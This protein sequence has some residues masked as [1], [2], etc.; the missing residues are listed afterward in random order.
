MEALKADELVAMAARASTLG[1]FRVVRS[2]SIRTTTRFGLR[3]MQSL[4]GVQRPR[5]ASFTSQNG[6]IRQGYRPVQGLGVA[7]HLC[8]VLSRTGP[9][10]LQRTA[11][12]TK[13]SVAA[14]PFFD[15]SVVGTWI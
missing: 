15:V 11:T 14:L 8:V 1:I 12:L 7:H 5:D 4:S 10:R 9:R 3:K 2:F 6:K 13:S